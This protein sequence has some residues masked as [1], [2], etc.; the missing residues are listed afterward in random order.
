MKSIIFLLLFSS[1]ALLETGVKSSVHLADKILNGE[2]E[3][4]DKKLNQRYSD[5]K[6]IEVEECRTVWVFSKKCETVVKVVRKDGR[7]ITPEEERILNE[8]FK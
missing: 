3:L 4:L 7:K 6:T 2:G 8:T 1:C 5:Y